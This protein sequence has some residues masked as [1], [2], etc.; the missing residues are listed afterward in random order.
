M[1]C[2]FGSLDTRATQFPNFD[3]NRG[4]SVYLLPV[5]GA[6]E[7]GMGGKWLE[8]SHLAARI[9]RL[10]RVWLINANFQ[11]AKRSWQKEKVEKVS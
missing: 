6:E 8:G 9:V 2:F 1:C 10:L 5:F 4:D 11:R 3:A 7:G